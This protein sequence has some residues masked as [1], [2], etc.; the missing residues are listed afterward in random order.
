ME[1]GHRLMALWLFKSEPDVFGWPDQVALGD[2]GGEWHGIRNYQARNNMRQMQVG[3]LGFFYHSG[4]GKAVVGIV[5][6]T[7]LSHPDSTTDDPRWDC[8]DVRAVRPLN[9]PVTLEQ[10]KADPRLGGMVLVRNS[11][12]SVQPVQ[13]SEWQIICDLGQTKG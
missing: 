11:R 7:G 8:V 13:A 5:A 10:I 2:K 3:D 4:V 9:V 12:L 6:V 1:K